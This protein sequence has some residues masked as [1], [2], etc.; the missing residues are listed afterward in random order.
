V[1]WV[2]TQIV[3]DDSSKSRRFGTIQLSQRFFRRSNY[4]FSLPTISRIQRQGLRLFERCLNW[5]LSLW[6]DTSQMPSLSTLPV[7]ESGVKSDS[8]VPY[9][10]RLFRPF[11]ASLEIGAIGNMV[12]QEFLDLL[13]FG[14]SAEAERFLPKVHHSPLAYIQRCFG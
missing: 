14:S 8:V 13:E 1:E 5:R 7:N 9:Y 4:I 10:H 6:C 12:V 11:D 3:A 2:N